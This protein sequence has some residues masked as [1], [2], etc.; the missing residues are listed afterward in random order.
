MNTRPRWLL[1]PV[2]GAALWVALVA[3]P[4]HSNHDGRFYFLAIAVAA[5]LLGAFWRGLSSARTAVLLISPAL[6]LAWWTAP[7][8]NDGF[9][10]LWF[11]VLLLALGPIALAH[12]IGSQWVARRRTKKGV[13]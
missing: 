1:P 7:H 12:R 3:L 8:D 9:W 10:I 13:A 2:T 5:L 11:P 6:G 4:G